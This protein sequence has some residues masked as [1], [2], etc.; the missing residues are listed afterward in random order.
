MDFKQRTE[1]AG[2][3]L[4][5]VGEKIENR[6]A[7]LACELG[8]LGSYAGQQG[9]EH[10]AKCLPESFEFRVLGGSGVGVGLGCEH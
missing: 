2:G 3:V 5:Q 9:C 8:S 1:S 10:P 7:S 4:T 6:K